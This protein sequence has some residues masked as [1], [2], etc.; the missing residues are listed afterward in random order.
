MSFNNPANIG[1][2][3]TFELNEFNQP[4]ITSEIETIKNVLLYVLFSKPGQYPS[5][6]NIGL[7][8]QSV[9]YSFYDKLDTEELKKELE[10]QCSALGFHIRTGSIGIMKTIYRKKPSLLIHIEGSE[11]FPDGYMKDSY[12]TFD[13]YLIGITFNESNEMIYNIN[14][15]SDT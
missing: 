4:R 11:T 13:R 3:L 8:I 15:E 1:Y 6:P 2:D 7:D 12:S 14:G 5:L 9:L 10:N